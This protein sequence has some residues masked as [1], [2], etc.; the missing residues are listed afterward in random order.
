MTLGVILLFSLVYFI[1]KGVIFISSV[2][3]KVILVI[4][5][6]VFGL[7]ALIKIWRR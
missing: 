6:I 4:V 3:L 2:V 1:L 5:L 7:S